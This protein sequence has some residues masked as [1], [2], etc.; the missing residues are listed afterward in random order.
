MEY[1]FAGIARRL[2]QLEGILVVYYLWII[3]R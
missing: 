3:T 2:V 1:R